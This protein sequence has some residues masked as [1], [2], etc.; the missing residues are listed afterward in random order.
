VHD[1]GRDADTTASF[2]TEARILSAT[3]ISESAHRYC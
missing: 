2:C 3:G 1:F